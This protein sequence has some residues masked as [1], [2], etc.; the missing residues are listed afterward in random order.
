L[1]NKTNKTNKANKANKAS[2]MESESQRLLRRNRQR[3]TAPRLTH[4]RIF[5]HPATAKTVRWNLFARDE[6]PDAPRGGFERGR[7]VQNIHDT[8]V[9]S[10]L[11]AK[12][13]QPVRS[14]GFITP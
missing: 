6:R 10:P 13:F 4:L 3:S 14:G 11:H 2:I 1:T 8:S 9:P 7:V 5:N 12:A